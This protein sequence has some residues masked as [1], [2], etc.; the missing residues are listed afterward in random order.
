M[1]LAQMYTL[2]LMLLNNKKLTRE[3]AAEKLGVS[4]RTVQ[5]YIEELSQAGIPVTALSGRT[6]GYSISDD[7]KLPYTL[8]TPEDIN[9]I[10]TSIG[11]MSRSFGDEMSDDLLNKLLSVSGGGQKHIMPSVI[12]DASAWNNPEAFRGKLDAIGAAIDQQ[13]TVSIRYTDKTGQPTERL[14]DPYCLALK[15]GIWYVYGWCHSRGGFRIFRLARMRTVTLTDDNFDKQEGADLGEALS[16]N[17]ARDVMLRIEF[18][19][20]CLPRI[21]EW[22]GEDAVKPGETAY[23]ATAMVSKGDELI[24]RL[25][26]LGSSVT[27][28]S[29]ESVRRQLCEVTKA[30]YKKYQN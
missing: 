8:F 27:V 15:E 4:E 11:G 18:D 28:L 3:Y 2:M 5:R 17:I 19:E 6:G 26:A 13:I 12:I 24:S 7:F 16:V 21:E 10:T 22:L 30:V 9:R 14:L 1:K 23:T 29:P 25:L 20:G